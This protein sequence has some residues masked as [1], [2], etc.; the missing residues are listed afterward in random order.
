MLLTDG[1]EYIRD[2]LNR[3]SINYLET[4]INSKDSN[5]FIEAKMAFIAMLSKFHIDYREYL[6]KP[7]NMSSVN[8]HTKKELNY[9]KGIK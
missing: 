6:S 1:Q 2:C 7:I 3:S 9:R 5:C 4:A 8:F